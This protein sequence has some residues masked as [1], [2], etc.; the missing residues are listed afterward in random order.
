ML[1]PHYLSKGGFP[2]QKVQIEHHVMHADIETA[3]GVLLAEDKRVTK[4]AVEEQL[5]SLLHSKGVNFNIG[6]LSELVG[7]DFNRERFRSFTALEDEAIRLS[8]EMFPEFYTK[9]HCTGWG[10]TE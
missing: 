6:G 7:M 2:V 3:V 8:K 4:T 5:R 9:G 1:K 10:K